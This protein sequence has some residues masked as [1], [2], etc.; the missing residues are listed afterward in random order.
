MSL[1]HGNEALPVAE[2]KAVAFS[3]SGAIPVGPDRMAGEPAHDTECQAPERGENEEA[4][5]DPSHTTGLEDAKVLEEQ[6]DFDDGGLREIDVVF[7]VE[8][9]YLLV[10][11]I[12]RAMSHT[13]LEVSLDI[14]RADIQH[15]L[16]KAILESCGWS[17]A[18][19]KLMRV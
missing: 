15:V 8:S 17:L 9:L 2:P 4:H 10:T 14:V 11:N 18:Y 13:Y 1:K 19:N 3:I 5:A 12:V 7:D 6:R 16:S